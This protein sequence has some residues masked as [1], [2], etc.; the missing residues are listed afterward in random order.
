MTAEAEGTLYSRAQAALLEQIESWIRA[1]MR[2]QEDL[3]FEGGH[4]EVNYTAPWA[5]VFLI[6]GDQIT[7]K[8][9]RGLRD[10]IIDYPGLYHGFYP[11][12]A[13]DIEHSVENWTVF[14][15]ELARAIP[16]D[17]RTLD[18]IEH[19]VH[20][21]GNWEDGVPDWYDW[22]AHRFRSEYLGTRVVKDQPPHDYSTYWDARLAELALTYYELRGEERYLEWAVD[23]GEGWLGLIMAGEDT[24][25]WVWLPIS[26]R[27]ETT[28]LYGEYP[29]DLHTRNVGWI[30]EIMRYFGHVYKLT[31]QERF[32]DGARK[33]IDQHSEGMERWVASYQECSGDM[34]YAGEVRRIE[35]A[36]AERC[37]QA[38]DEPLPDILLL[39]GVETY[40]T[41]KYG[42]RGA[43]GAIQESSVT[44]QDLVVAH[45]ATGEPQL[46]VRAMDQ[47]RV[48]LLMA[49]RT[50]RDGREHGCNG[51]FVHAA[52]R[53]AVDVLCA[54]S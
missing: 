36:T 10:Q 45:K 19:V 39:E 50:L 8:F 32:R 33:I 15:S 46:A 38:L 40:P 53:T 18:A 13:W 2:R 49:D 14:M 31:Q 16:D 7:L 44:P 37:R 41:R 30:W 3:P 42:Y 52:G 24:G 21:V 48:E 28:R 29:E 4:D 26:D 51:R 47:A 20:H 35:L 6:T 25:P 27:E 9:M 22:D 1:A 5:Q 54:V 11:D 12:G 43:A 17:D 23:Y 34:H